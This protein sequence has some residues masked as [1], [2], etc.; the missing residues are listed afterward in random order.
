MDDKLITVIV[1]VYNVETYLERCIN[2]I[3]NQTYKKL[4]IILVDDCSLDF[5]G[6]I[7]DKYASIDSRIKVIHR[8]ENGGISLARNDALDIAQGDYITFVDSD[9]YIFPEMYED[10]KNSIE[11]CNVDICVCPWLYENTNGEQVVDIDKIDNS[12]YGYKKSRVFEHYLYEGNYENG[13]VA[14]VWNKMY[15]RH[16]FKNIRFSGLCM[17]D[18]EINDKINIKNVDIYVIDR[19][20]YVYCQN[21]NSIT[22]ER[23]SKKKLHFLDVLINRINLF[24]ND[25]NISRETKRLFCNIFIEYWYKLKSENIKIPNYYRN[26]LRKYLIDLIRDFPNNYKLIMRTF[27]FL[28]SPWIYEKLVAMNEKN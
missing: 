21:L 1:P 9:D 19:P 11:K 14:A 20:Y 5:S 8:K 28:F 23:F 26:N 22:N 13:M 4:E 16:L 25:N 12:I 15:K 3:I 17:E 2:S 7:C 27:L 18:E 6:K 24:Y 10:M